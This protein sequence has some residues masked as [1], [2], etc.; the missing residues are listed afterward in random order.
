MRC[1]ALSLVARRL[2][3]F[4]LLGDRISML[5]HPSFLGNR[6]Y[7]AHDLCNGW[8]VDYTRLVRVWLA[9]F[10]F[11]VLTLRRCVYIFFFCFCSFTIAFVCMHSCVCVCMARSLGTVPE[12]CNSAGEAVCI[13]YSLL[14]FLCLNFF[15]WALTYANGQRSCSVYSFFL[16]FHLNIIFFLL[17]VHA[18][19]SM[20]LFFFSF[21]HLFCCCWAM[22]SNAWCINQSNGCCV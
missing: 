20:P 2:G 14:F 9:F 21:F 22:P 19:I 6:K 3:F 5:M 8:L 18:F 1:V 11:H 15:F 4:F 10:F 16:L 12:L 13:F 7:N 17:F